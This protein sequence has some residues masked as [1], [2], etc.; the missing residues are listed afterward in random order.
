MHGKNMYL[1][2]SSNISK[3]TWNY[4][5]TISRDVNNTRFNSKLTQYSCI[6]S[7]TVFVTWQMCDWAH[8]YQH[9]RIVRSRTNVLFNNWDIPVSPHPCEQLSPELNCSRWERLENPALT[10]LGLYTDT[11]KGPLILNF[12]KKQIATFLKPEEMKTI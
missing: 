11:Q 1:I 4:S 10:V 7:F 12:M 8:R 2:I 3:K 9:E 6:I 5:S